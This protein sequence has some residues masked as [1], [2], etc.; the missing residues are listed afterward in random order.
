MKDKDEENDINQEGLGREKG[1][2]CAGGHGNHF[3]RG[4]GR[5]ES[6]FNKIEEIRQKQLVRRRGRGT[7]R[8]RGGRRAQCYHCQKYGHYAFECKNKP[9]KED[10][11][12]CAEAGE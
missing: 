1:R 4:R 9:I 11:V 7:C 6:D 2:M 5:F 3:G 8:Q 12:Y 10:E